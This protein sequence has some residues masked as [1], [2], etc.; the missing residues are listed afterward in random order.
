MKNIFL[1]SGELL[2]IVCL[3]LFIIFVSSQDK[4]SNTP[5]EQVSS[6]VTSACDTDELVKR[7]ALKLKKVFSFEPDAFDGFTY[8][9]SDSVMDVREVLVIR[10][11]D[12]SQQQAVTDAI[13]KYVTDKHTLFEGYAPKE[14][15]LLA[16]HVLIAQNGYVLFYIGQNSEL[17]SS[18][19]QQSL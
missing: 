17:V 15:E 13:S 18:S 16:S 12:Q 4:V 14:S 1:K 5:F 8:Y 3:A 11:K 10:L 19:F 9:S 2:C 7:D 6:A